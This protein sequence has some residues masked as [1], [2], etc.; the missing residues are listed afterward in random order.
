MMMLFHT[1]HYLY[2]LII[3]V[4]NDT[5]AIHKKIV[6]QGDLMIGVL[7]PIHEQPDYKGVSLLSNEK[8]RCGPIRDQY[9]IQRA[10]A[11]LYLLDKLNNK[12]ITNF[13]NDIKIGIDI[14]DDCWESSIT[15][16]ETIDII[17]DSICFKYEEDMQQNSIIVNNKSNSFN[18]TNKC[19]T[20]SNESKDYQNK[21]IA[22]IGPGGSSA[23]INVQNLLR[24][25]NIPQ[26]G[27]SATS[28]YLSNKRMYRTFIRVVPS[29]YLQVKTMIDIVL[30][31]NWT[32]VHAV[33]TVGSYGQ[34]G[35]EAFRNE[36]LHHNICIAEYEK[37][38]DGA[39]QHE[40]ERVILKLN[41]TTQATAIV[42]FC[43]G[44][45]VRGLLQAINKFK[46]KGRFSILGS[47]GW[48]DRIDVAQGFYE[49]A[50]GS[51]SVKPYSPLVEEFNSYF[52]HLNP[53]NNKR[54][55]W[56]NEYWEDRFKCFV[57]EKSKEIYRESCKRKCPNKF[58]E[59][60]NECWLVISE[61]VIS[62]NAHN[63]CKQAHI[64]A[65]LIKSS[66]TQV[67][68]G[69]LNRL[70][71]NHERFHVVYE[72]SNKNK[73]CYQNNFVKNSCF[74]AKVNIDS[75]CIDQIDCS[76]KSPFI[77]KYTPQNEITY[78]DILDINIKDP[79]L[80]YVIDALL[81]IAYSLKGAH[82]VVII[83]SS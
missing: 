3:L 8:K 36:T 51:F 27:Y 28:T 83:I 69:L 74:S 59:H 67:I 21:I 9:G 31:F 14:R 55:V 44:E 46:L 4:I 12:T 76:L 42:C 75:V 48:S 57:D 15:L 82:D 63:E 66:E 80:S 54:N 7:L 34:A 6:Q 43:Y 39:E 37:I 50:L 22:F 60:E 35:M 23:T 41:R 58:V 13:L 79:Y 65:N 70:K 11:L 49:E 32:F 61:A 71:I 10:E 53:D 24:L 2:V 29:D 19:S 26:V 33:F 62:K 52:A 18:M 78:P 40:F 16:E 68:I 1:L 30:K 17:R 47:D 77:C 56:F 64:K 72:K 38:Q 81:A 20:A 73:Y 5:H 25:Y 45:T